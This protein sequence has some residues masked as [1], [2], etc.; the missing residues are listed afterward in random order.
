[1]RA[2]ESRNRTST[3]LK[4]IVQKGQLLKPFQR[5][6]PTSCPSSRKSGEVSRTFTEIK[7]REECSA[8]ADPTPKSFWRLSKQ[9]TELDQQGPYFSLGQ[10]AI[11]KW[12]TRKIR[13]ESHGAHRSPTPF[14]R[15]HLT[16][17][18]RA[19]RLQGT[20]IRQW[21]CHHDQP[22][23]VITHLKRVRNASKCID[24]SEDHWGQHWGGT[25]RFHKKSHHKPGRIDQQSRQ[26]QPQ[27]FLRAI[28]EKLA[29]QD[30]SKWLRASFGPLVSW[31]WRYWKR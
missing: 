16:Q 4:G 9:P 17:R 30:M 13:I 2:T 7:E 12:I 6:Q 11:P 24:A 25:A 5:I 26:D 29:P 21:Q 22:K 18:G 10:Q 20:Q 19:F 15:S 8:P 1:M 14:L 31:W 23:Q 27:W 3:H 28:L